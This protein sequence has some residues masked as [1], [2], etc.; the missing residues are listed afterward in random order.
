MELVHDLKERLEKAQNAMYN[1]EYPEEFKEILSQKI[2]FDGKETLLED[3]MDTC[4]QMIPLLITTD[5]LDF[6]KYTKEFALYAYDTVRM[7]VNHYCPVGES[8]KA[9]VK[10]TNNLD[11]NYGDNYSK[12]EMM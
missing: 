6:G 2:F 7:R 9:F 1:S 10:R 5:N 3:I 8:W 11:S 4:P 12:H